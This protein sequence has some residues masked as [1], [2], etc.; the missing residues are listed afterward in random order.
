MNYE[1]HEEHAGGQTLK[2]V[3]TRSKQGL[4]RPPMYARAGAI[5]PRQ[6]PSR[7]ALEQKKESFPVKENA[8]TLRVF[9]SAELSHFDLYEDDG[10]THAYEA[11]EIL[12]THIS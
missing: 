5:F 10:V 2:G 3:A 6:I 9:P 11:G 4:F 12:K 7:P 1:T 8:L